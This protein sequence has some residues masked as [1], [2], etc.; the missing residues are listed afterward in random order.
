M[1]HVAHMN[2]K[3]PQM[4]ARHNLPPDHFSRRWL[5]GIALL[6]IAAIAAAM[7]STHPPHDEASWLNSLASTGD[8]GAQ[9]EIGLAYR[10]GRYGLDTDNSK[11]LYWLQRAAQNGNA[12]AEASVGDMYAA[13]T[14]T[15]KD[16]K[17]AMHWWQQAS[18]DGNHEARLH[19]AE[20]LIQSGD[21]HQAE[22][23]LK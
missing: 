3:L 8:G 11:A 1:Q 6:A 19:L 7:F 15:A 9:L 13:G 4:D 5:A 16:L 10:D 23:V 14:G 12:Y 21:V 20:A 17:A 2:D 22:S 18:Q